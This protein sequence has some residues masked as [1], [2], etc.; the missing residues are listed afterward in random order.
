LKLGGYGG[1]SRE[2]KRRLYI[3][4]KRILV[5]LDGSRFAGRALRYAGEIAQRFDAEVVLMQVVKPAVPV[6]ATTGAVPG[7][8]SPSTAKITVQIAHEEDKRNTAR[9]KRYL[10]RKVR[11]I[12]SQGVEGSYQVE[13][14]D[15]AQ[16]IMRFA[17][18]GHIDLVVMTTQGKSGFKR[19]VM[20]S[21]TDEVIRESGKPVLV[22]KPQTR[23]K[24]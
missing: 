1:L 10:S 8:E 6:A 4:F 14:G 20:G 5:P 2:L 13:I 22:I 3:M 16:S 21:V 24:K 9:A 19:A 15:P 7:I 11:K 18:K 23:G 12:R 17:R